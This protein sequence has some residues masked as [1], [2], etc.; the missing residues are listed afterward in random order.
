VGRKGLRSSHFEREGGE[1]FG[2]LVVPAGSGDTPEFH[3][4]GKLGMDGRNG[5]KDRAVLSHRATKFIRL[6]SQLSKNL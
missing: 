5:I 6:L 1:N 4:L 3:T 2:G